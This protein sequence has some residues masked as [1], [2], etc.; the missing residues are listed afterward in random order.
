MTILELRCRRG[1]PTRRGN[2]LRCSPRVFMQPSTVALSLWRSRARGVRIS[3]PKKGRR[4]TY[5]VPMTST[6][7]GQCGCQRRR[8]RLSRYRSSALSACHPCFHLIRTCHRG[9]SGLQAMV[10]L[11]CAAVL[12]LVFLRSWPLLF[13]SLSSFLSA[14]LSA[15]PSMSLSLIFPSPLGV[16]S[17]LS[18]LFCRS[19]KYIF[20][21]FV[22]NLEIRLR[23]QIEVSH[24][25]TFFAFVRRVRDMRGQWIC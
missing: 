13:A 20:G 8:P 25:T 6:Q 14:F 22:S 12:A 23:D 10:P 2:P 7:P 1:S 9:R 17:L 15:R 19:F 3:F 21:A 4:G 5:A 24:L 16:A 18:C 11:L